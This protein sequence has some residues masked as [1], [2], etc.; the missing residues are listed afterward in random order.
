[1]KRDVV[2]VSVICLAYNH[3][4]YVEEALNSIITQKTDFTFEIIVHDDCS[5]D[6]TTEIIKT[7]EEKYPD[8][9]KPI[10]EKTNQYSQDKDVYID[11]SLPNAKGRYIA[12]CEC[13]D[14]WMDDSK[15]QRQYDIMEA[16]PEIDMCACGTS[17]VWADKGIEITESRP[18]QEDGIF[19]AEE[20]VEKVLLEGGFFSAA[21]LFY[22][23]SLFDSLMEFEKILFYDHT[24]QM[25]GALRG[26]IY[27][28]DRKMTVYR[29][30][31]E[32][33]WITRY[34]K[35]RN[36]QIA[37]L[38]KKEDMVREFDRETRGAF[39]AI[40]E[41]H[42]SMPGSFFEMLIMNKDAI[43]AEIGN[44][45][46]PQIGNTSYLWG[47]G[48]RGYAFQEFCKLEGINLS[49]VCDMQNINVGGITE[50]GYP[51]TDT[52]YVQHNSDIIFAS[53]N[54]I[55]NFLVEKKYPGHLIN[56]QNYM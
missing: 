26:G 19:T 1:M 29:R 27:Y 50:Y 40:I 33:S 46:S 3:A 53:N 35:D 36:L 15:L 45:P 38:K 55:Y 25:K 4:K 12:F 48:M 54:T 42:M 31:V 16:H 13:D 11:I 17:E 39:H 41:K 47:L 10:Y 23:K 32:G 2:E 22:R 7:Y 28:I 44:I 6:G 51:I 14:Y 56:L 21:S 30:W 18:R 5:T 43:K 9:I 24:L 37:H 52:N 20:V 8:L 34:K 49:G